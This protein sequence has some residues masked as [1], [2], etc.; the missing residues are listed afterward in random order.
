MSEHENEKHIQ[1]LDSL[2]RKEWKR[3]VIV[4]LSE[5]NGEGAEGKPTAL[6][7]NTFAFG[8]GPS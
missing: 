3:P 6:R 8:Y 4:E 5:A 1:G 7:E 2:A